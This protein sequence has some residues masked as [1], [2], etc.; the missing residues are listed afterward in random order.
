MKLVHFL[1]PYTK[2]NSECIRY[3]NIRPDTIK[4]LEKNI[5][6]MCFDL[7]DSKISFDPPLRIM[8][9]TTE[10]NQWHLIKLKSFCTAKKT[11]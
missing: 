9:I 10:I 11:I 5:G 3:L 1:T 2:I 7:N 6:R 4:F 8:R